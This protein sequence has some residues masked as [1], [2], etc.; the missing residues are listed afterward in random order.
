MSRGRAVAQVKQTAD[1]LWLLEDDGTIR[2]PLI[3]TVTEPVL[4]MSLQMTLCV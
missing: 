2:F 1:L 3:S 4:M